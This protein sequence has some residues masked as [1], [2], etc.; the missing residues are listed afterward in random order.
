MANP[1]LGGKQI[2]P[3]CSAKFYDLNKR[4]AHCPKCG[5]EFDPEE[6]LRTRR[7]RVRSIAPEAETEDEEKPDQVTDDADELE[8]EEDG[9]VELDQAVNE[10]DVVD[11]EDGGESDQVSGAP[12]DELGVDFVEDDLAEDEADDV[13]FLEDEDDDGLSED[14]LDGLPEE[15]IDDR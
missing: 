8:E 1:A 7:V 14:D 2:C 11:D 10:P 6:L 3:V 4:P 5:N 13:P 9:A 15:D 12:G